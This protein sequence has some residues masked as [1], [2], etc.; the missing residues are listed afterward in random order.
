[1]IYTTV[2]YNRWPRQWPPSVP[3]HERW[4]NVAPKTAAWPVEMIGTIVRDTDIP[5]IVWPETS[6]MFY[7]GLDQQTAIWQMSPS[8]VG[9]GSATRFSRTVIGERDDP[10]GIFNATEFFGDFVATPIS[11][12]FLQQYVKPFEFERNIQAEEFFVEINARTFPRPFPAVYQFKTTKCGR[13]IE[14][15]DEL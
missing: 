1:M 15:P 12:P 13:E 10:L 14:L 11:S 5:G 7:Q 2:G 4:P 6:I 3:L 8:L 9:P